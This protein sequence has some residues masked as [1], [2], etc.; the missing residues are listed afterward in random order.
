VR[1]HFFDPIGLDPE[2]QPVPSGDEPRTRYYLAGDAASEDPEHFSADPNTKMLREVVG[3][4][5]WYLSADEFA[6][7]IVALRRRRSFGRRGEEWSPWA[8]MCDPVHSTVSA[9]L[10]R[11][12]AG[13]MELGVY[14][15]KPPSLRPPGNDHLVAVGKV[16]GG[17]T[18]EG[19]T[20]AWLAFGD[21]TAVLMINSLGGSIADSRYLPSGSAPLELKAYTVL[22]LAARAAFTRP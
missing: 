8:E 15:D 20:T 2:I 7:F 11:F 14:L 17:D 10:K 13:C 1:E 4:S 19:P 5:S 18:P 3:A 22:E 12:R 9:D 16:G 21:L 6:R